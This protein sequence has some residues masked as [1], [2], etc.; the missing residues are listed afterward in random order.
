MGTQ[1]RETSRKAKEA[2]AKYAMIYNP[3]KDG[4]LQPVQGDPFSL[5]GHRG[6][7]TDSFSFNSIFIDR[8]NFPHL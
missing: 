1:D 7:H 4:V 5:W 3:V 6:S 8:F 2:S